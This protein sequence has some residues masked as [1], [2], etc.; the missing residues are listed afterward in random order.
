MDGARRHRVVIADDSEDIRLCLAEII[1]DEY[2]VVAMVEDGVQ[3]VLAVQA[4]RPD[5]VVVDVVM[6][7]LNGLDALQRMNEAGI[8][9]TAVMVSA[10]TE[11]A[12][13]E[14]ALEL[15]AIGYV[16]KASADADLPQAIR[17]ALRGERFVS[18]GGE[19]RE[20]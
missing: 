17:A 10:N 16:A 18:K 5:V 12:Y 6:P 7:L 3:L 15:G 20:W 11:D 2:D 14:R 9:F 1:A 19:T 4:M 13:I 8:A